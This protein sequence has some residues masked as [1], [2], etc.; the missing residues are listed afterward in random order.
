MPYSERPGF[1]LG[2]ILFSRG[3]ISYETLQDLGAGPH[4]ERILLARQRTPEEVLGDVVLKML[5]LPTVTE[6]LKRSRARLEDEVRLA[7]YLDHPNI[8][9]VQGLHEARGAL[10]VITECVSGRSLEGLIQLADMRGRCFSESFVLH[11]GASV[12]AALAHAHGRRD[13]RGVPLGI[14]HRAIDP[15]RVRVSWSGRVKLTD[16]GLARAHLPGRRI[17]SLPRAR[18]D[19]FYA[20]PEA[21]LGGPEDARADLFMLGLTLLELATGRHL[22]DAGDQ[23][24]RQLWARVP[25][26]DRA[27]VRHAMARVKEEWLHPDPEELVTRAA[28]FVPEDVEA[29]VAGLSPALR[30]IL[31][32]LL[33]REPAERYTAALDVE[34]EMRQRLRE[35]G[36]YGG[37]SAVRDIR[38]ALMEAGERLG[39]EG[40]LPGAGFSQDDVTTRPS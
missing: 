14:V 31:H 38:Q 11:V 24:L 3:R 4:G 22:F 37:A 23:G 36:E 32:G 9:R 19:V 8:A 6:A 13:A 1:P 10:Y 12:A 27:R 34:L 2:V 40:L 17:T 21:L 30:R 28:T 18:G 39:E 35:L 26:G 20:S 16:F 33:R 25:R 15:T 5:P 7:T 29:M